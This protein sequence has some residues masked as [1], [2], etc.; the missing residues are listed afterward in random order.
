MKSR[1]KAVICVFSLF[2]LLIASAYINSYYKALE[3][4]LE[5]LKNAEYIEDDYLV[6][7][8]EV[9]TEQTKAGIIF[10]PGGKVEYTAYAPLMEA[11]AREG[12][13]CVL[14]K[15]P[16]NLA[17]FDINAAEG[18][19][20]QFQTVDK[21]YMAGHSLGGSM[22]ASYIS[23]H[24][25]EFNGLILL[26][27]YS[28]ELL[29][30]TDLAVLSIY[31][32]EDQILNKDDYMKYKTNLPANY[33]EE[34]IAGGCHAYFGNYGEQEGDGEANITAEHQQRLTVQAII[35]FVN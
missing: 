30:D 19:Q 9:D 16:G 34:V 21:W 13:L 15:M 26:A 12:I 10:Y 3:P 14:V 23:E 32:T 35:N 17:V 24:P 4:A 31:G 1:I 27:S 5:A 6:F 33:V 25:S 22:A 2:L 29:L 20:E 11:C 8:S 7:D 28:T 18:I